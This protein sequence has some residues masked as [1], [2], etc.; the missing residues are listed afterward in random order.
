MN[1][2]ETCVR[3]NCEAK[4]SQQCLE[5]TCRH[6][7]DFFYR[8][9]EIAMTEAAREGFQMETDRN[10]HHMK[11]LQLTGN[12]KAD[13]MSQIPNPLDELVDPSDITVPEAPEAVSAEGDH[14]DAIDA[15]LGLD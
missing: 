14:T 5:E 6:S 12:A 9:S 11:P 10:G 3:I 7:I 4:R 13:A 15:A 8:M 2:Y 1:I